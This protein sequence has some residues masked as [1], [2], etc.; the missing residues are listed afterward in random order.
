MCP[1]PIVRISKAVKALAPGEILEVAA[2]D[3][4]FEPDVR[5]WCEKMKQPLK[6]LIRQGSDVTALI[7]KA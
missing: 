3:P 5:A 2:D 6:S 4:A 7:Q 1:M